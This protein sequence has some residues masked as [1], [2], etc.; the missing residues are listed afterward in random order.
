[1]DFYHEAQKEL[2]K[3][4]S[5][6]KEQARGKIQQLR[7]SCSEFLRLEEEIKDLGLLLVKSKI[8]PGNWGNPDEI[9]GKISALSQKKSEIL[10]KEGILPVDEVFYCDICKDTGYV[11]VNG[12]KQRCS[13]FRL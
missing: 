4:I 11:Q 5:E 2:D 1:M 8:L 6:T 7:N 13:C 10:T 12:K 3:R 9:Q